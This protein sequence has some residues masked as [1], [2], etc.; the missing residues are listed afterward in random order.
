MA[1]RFSALMAASE[2]FF[3]FLEMISFFE[4]EMSLHFRIAGEDPAVLYFSTGTPSIVAIIGAQVGFTIGD[5]A[6]LAATEWNL[7]LMGVYGMDIQAAVEHGQRALALARAPELPPAVDS[8][9]A[10]PSRPGGRL[11]LPPPRQP[12]GTAPATTPRAE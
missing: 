2:I 9:P 5:K 12:Q 3:I 6:G 7:A 11:L 4:F 10:S 8:P 1:T